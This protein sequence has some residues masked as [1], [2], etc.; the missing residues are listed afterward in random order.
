MR[1]R[2]PHHAESPLVRSVGWVARPADN[3]IGTM[4]QQPGSVGNSNSIRIMEPGADP[5]YPNRYVKFTNEHNQPI[6]LDG[7]PGPR[8]ETHIPRNP[9]GSYPLPKGWP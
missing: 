7:R 4:Y 3:G 2:G 5:R 1:L 9:D 8:A 6:T